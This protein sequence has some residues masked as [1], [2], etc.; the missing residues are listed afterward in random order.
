MDKVKI[1]MVGCGGIAGAH[2][3]GLE[4][5]WKAGY[6]KFEIVATCDVVKDKAAAM[7]TEIAKFQGS[8]PEV[9]ER[10]DTLLDNGPEFDAAD[11]CTLHCEHHTTAIPC[12]QAGKHV[13]IEKPL[14]ITL[15]AGRKM[16]DAARKARRILHTAENYRLTPQ[17]RAI[18]WAIK[19]GMIGNVRMIYWLQV[20]ERLWYWTWREH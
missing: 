14:A 13:T 1:A 3:N 11:I 8:K 12:L 4:L 19:N 7:A 18:K 20:R 10:L 17:H 15:R 6:R 9:Y 5:L 2:R 16:L